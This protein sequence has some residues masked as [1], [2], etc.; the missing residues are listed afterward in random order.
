[1]LGALCFVV[2][3]PV[4][5]GGPV[6]V[7]GHAG[8][9]EHCVQYLCPH[10][11]AFFVGFIAGWVLELLLRD[12]VLLEHPLGF[13]CVSRV[14][15]VCR[16]NH[17]WGLA[18]RC[19]QTGAL[20]PNLCTPVPGPSPPPQTLVADAHSLQLKLPPPNVPLPGCRTNPAVASGAPLVELLMVTS[21]WSVQ[22]LKTLCQVRRVRSW[23]CFHP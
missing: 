13:F 21:V 20:L 17:W 10:V 5:L 18:T 22:L 14:C 9:V 1:M 19:T 8:E 11:N 12:A 4:L 15:V 7:L 3:V 6:Q 2:G 23:V 16:V